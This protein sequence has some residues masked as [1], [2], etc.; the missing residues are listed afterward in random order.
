MGQNGPH[1]NLEPTPKRPLHWQVAQTVGGIAILGVWF[2]LGWL[3]I[4]R[5]IA[6][7]PVATFLLGVAVV[8]GLGLL[9]WSTKPPRP[10]DKPKIPHP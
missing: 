7:G 10:P 6:G 9:R 4:E 2:F 8:L 1:L 5:R 3:V